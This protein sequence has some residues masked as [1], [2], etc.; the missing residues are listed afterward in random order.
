MT[1]SQRLQ[2]EN[3]IKGVEVVPPYARLDLT[4]SKNAAFIALTLSEW[5]QIKIILEAWKSWH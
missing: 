3:L 2:V 1:A 4:S 5:Q